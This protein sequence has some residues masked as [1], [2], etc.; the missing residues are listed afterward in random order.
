MCNQTA[1]VLRTLLVDDNS[2]FLKALTGML[3]LEPRLAVI[4]YALS[5]EEAVRRTLA[6]NPDLV[7]MDISMPGLNGLDATRIIKAQPQSPRIIIVTL[8]ND[9]LLATAARY[10]NADGFI[11]KTEV[12]TELLP[13]IWQICPHPEETETRTEMLITSPEFPGPAS[14][15]VMP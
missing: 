15:H 8:S 11:S 9:E 5:G 2:C 6:L 10:A 1:P 4:G 3:L 7:L 14:A 12:S 13:L